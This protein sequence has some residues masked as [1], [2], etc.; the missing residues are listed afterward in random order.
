MAPE[1]RHLVAIRKREDHTQI[2]GRHFSA[3]DRREQQRF[4]VEHEAAGYDLYFTVNP[5][6]GELHKKASKDD[7]AEDRWLW[8]DMDPR[9]SK[10]LEEERTAM[11]ALGTTN[12]S[13]GTPKPNRVIDSGRGYWLFWKLEIAHP[14]K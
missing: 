6:K 12:S 3:D 5:V 14:G 2:R 10:P 9:E 8:V 1:K 4:I 11:L 7:I 13:A